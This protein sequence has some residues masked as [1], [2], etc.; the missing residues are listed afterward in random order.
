MLLLFTIIWGMFVF[1]QAVMEAKQSD[2]VDLSSTDRFSI[3][4]IVKDGAIVSYRP[5]PSPKDDLKELYDNAD[6][7]GDKL[8]NEAKQRTFYENQLK[9]KATQKLKSLGFI[10]IND[11]VV[12]DF[13]PIRLE[14]NFTPDAYGNSLR[15]KC[16]LTLKL[17][18]T[19]QIT[20]SGIASVKAYDD[21]YLEALEDAMKAINRDN[22]KEKLADDLKYVKYIKILEMPQNIDEKKN[23]ELFDYLKKRLEEYFDQKIERFSPVDMKIFLAIKDELKQFMQMKRKLDELVSL[24]NLI[25]CTSLKLVLVSKPKGDIFDVIKPIKNNTSTSKKVYISFDRDKKIE[26]RIFTLSPSPLLNPGSSL[27]VI[28]EA[29]IIA[30]KLRIVESKQYGGV[31]KQFGLDLLHIKFDGNVFIE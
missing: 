22:L 26:E 6:S 29:K 12:K 24:Q 17:H 19:P 31:L 21:P 3:L 15:I 25:T 28:M 23:E 8:N 16:Q 14:A 11:S 2:E 4:S 20:V 18:Q 9:E 30:G 7:F 5:S 13:V 27:T 10:V 1:L